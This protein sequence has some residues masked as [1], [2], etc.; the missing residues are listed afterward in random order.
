[1][2]KIL[3]YLILFL[4]FNPLSAHD[5]YPRYHNID[6]LHYEFALKLSDSTDSITGRASVALHILDRTDSVILDLRGTD[7]KGKGM[8]VTAVSI[9]GREIG[10]KQGRDKLYLATGN[11]I[12]VNDTVEI[13]IEYAGIPADG[14]IIS[15]NKYGDRTFFADHWPNRAH[16]YLP[17]I[18]HP[19]DKAT[20]DFIITAPE[21]YNVVA[22]G[23]M[24][25]QSSLSGHLKLTHWSE[26]IPIPVKVMTFGVA[27]F[28]VQFAGQA[29]NVPVW[30][31]VFPQN[32]REGFY[33]YSVAHKP[34]EFYN[35]LVGEYPFEKLANVQ[36]KTIY[37]GLEN[38]G[39]IFYYENSVTGLGKADLLIAHEIA[40]QWFG[41][42]VTEADWHHIWLSEGF[43]TYLTSMYEE[44][45][46]GRDKFEADMSRSR[47]M[48]IKSYK[49]KPR[50]VIDTAIV[51]LM[52]LLSVNSYQK[53]AWVL[54]MLR[55]EIGDSSFAKGL[56]AF[57]SQYRNS[58][59]L[60]QDFEHVMEEV[61]GKD[62]GI[63]FTQWLYRAGQP[64]IR[65]SKTINK[66]DG[67]TA[68][69][70]EQTQRDLF[71]FRLDL[72]IKD[73]S[74]EKIENIAVKERKT[75]LIIP[76]ATVTDVSPDPNVKLLY[77][78]ADK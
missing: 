45:T 37:G 8:N 64:E 52:D 60:S 41:D 4:T 32:R 71:E 76:S 51:N 62:L 5:G 53:G 42:C 10:W 1:M 19:Y 46:E 15:M 66:K 27:R 13:V 74:G 11:S 54:H 29:D 33:D 6:I 39:A 30:S 77:E 65:I 57:Y 21:Q 61:S 12:M 20:V 70:V 69:Y 28:A 18:D 23:I 17:C 47:A 78:I 73:A 40:H 36:S 58:N 22:N 75:S 26:H 59:A 56:K 31:W 43:A 38:A 7:N 44:A 72:R 55:V 68:I 25:E 63:F 67:N 9:A 3:S 49:K 50:P 34:L 14:L 24:T 48:V 2:K 35:R 16:N